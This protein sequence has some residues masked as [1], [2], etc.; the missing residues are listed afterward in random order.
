MS[1]IFSHEMIEICLERER[2][3]EGEGE[4]RRER[5]REK[6]RRREGEE[7]EKREKKEREREERR[8]RD[9]FTEYITTERKHAHFV[10]KLPAVQIIKD[11]QQK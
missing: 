2:E 9:K 10:D 8:I 4:R 5:R 6:R 3:G 1:I 11:Q 7:K